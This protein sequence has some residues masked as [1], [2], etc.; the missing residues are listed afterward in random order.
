MEKIKP[1]IKTFTLGLVSLI[2]VLALVMIPLMT[3]GKTAKAATDSYLLLD[4]IES[5]GTQYINTGY[6]PSS[7]TKMV[8]DTQITT[9]DGTFQGHG[10]YST[11]NST[12]WVFTPIGVNTA[13]TIIQ[14]HGTSVSTSITI[15]GQIGRYTAI[16]DSLNSFGSINS[17]T[18]SLNSMTYPI[19]PIYLFARNVNGTALNFF[20]GRVYSSQ[21]YD[22][23]ILVRDFVPAKRSSD[24]VLG[25][26]DRVNGTFYTNQG[27]GT[28]SAGYLANEYYISD[29]LQSHGTEYIDTSY[30]P[31]NNTSSIMTASFNSSTVGNDNVS[32]MALWDNSSG[33]TYQYYNPTAFSA[34]NKIHLV[35]VSSQGTVLSYDTNKHTS[36][37][38]IKNG[39]AAI[40]SN[41]VTFSPS[42]ATFNYSLYIFATHQYNSGTL[43][44]INRGNTS[45]YSLTI[46][47]NNTLQR[48]MIPVYDPQTNQAGLWDNVNSVWYGNLGT[49]SLGYSITGGGTI[50][51]VGTENAL[52]SA[53]SSSV[54]GDIIVMTGNITTSSRTIT[55]G[56]APVYFGSNSLTSSYHANSA[57]YTTE[58]WYTSQWSGKL[59]T[60]KMLAGTTYTARFQANVSSGSVFATVL[61]TSLS[62][63]IVNITSGFTYT[64]DS[65]AIP[66]GMTINLNGY[67][68]LPPAQTPMTQVGYNSDPSA[69]TASTSFTAGNTY[70]AIYTRPQYTSYLTISSDTVI[71]V[72]G[73]PQGTR[74]DLTTVQFTYTYGTPV[75]FPNPTR[76][77]Y[78]F[79]GWFSNNQ[80]PIP[81]IS[82]T[83]Y[84]S[85]TFEAR[86]V[87]A[88]TISIGNV[89][90]F[91]QLSGTFSSDRL[92]LFTYDINWGSYT[93]SYNVNTMFVFRL[94][95]QAGT[96]TIMTTQVS[97]MGPNGGYDMGMGAFYFPNDDVIEWG[98][99]YQIRIDGNPAMWYTISD[100]RSIY[101]ITQANYTEASGHTA[102]RT[103]AGN[104]IL[105]ICLALEENWQDIYRLVT[106]TT[107]GDMVLTSGLGT[108][109]TLD[110]LPNAAN[111]VPD[112][113]PGKS[114]EHEP[115]ELP[116][117]DNTGIK[118]DPPELIQR[119]QT[120]YEGTWVQ[121]SFEAVGDLFHVSWRLVTSLICVVLWVIL[122]AI[123]Q[124]RW[125]TTDAGMWAGAVVMGVGTTMGIMEWSIVGASAILL[126]LYGLYIVFWRQG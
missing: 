19:V 31:S 25:L 88:P 9:L 95:D 103:A 61:G 71:D 42:S 62:G 12:N 32:I 37:L 43:A 49:G 39:Y 99:E 41:K 29:Y 70:Y 56:N 106:T 64:S 7:T 58:G 26:L 79:A 100:L 55:V 68:I 117:D 51:Q 69:T 102:N 84:G 48:N 93:P 5:D 67:T 50:Y 17:K 109:Y 121:S 57:L 46:F 111:L 60:G 3:C 15:T 4:Y 52:N 112:I 54:A 18:T 83:D 86:W 72:S 90:V 115:S 65:F 80:G 120:Q 97:T 92:I 119:W 81:G 78:S 113:F 104:E 47:T 75:T 63:D 66:S 6:V 76:A 1:L 118:D 40:D 107:D 2:T 27:T 126:A 116:N 77:G 124:R 89:R 21:I 108:Q 38:N 74:T 8:I 59:T 14:V 85:K 16:L 123:S 22:S 34:D 110:V 105:S 114:T 73:L 23:G 10:A 53:L 13:D 122:A 20:K 96:N 28:F 44:V 45:I 33:T 94:M 91:R 36:E 101:N 30:V 87:V 98:G 125:G 24:G 35:W 82:S 11:I